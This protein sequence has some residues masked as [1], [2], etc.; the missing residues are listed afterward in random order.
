MAKPPIDSFPY[1][2][3]P[4][5][6]RLQK[7]I[8]SGTYVYARDTDGEIWVLPDG[9]HLHP[10]ILGGGRSAEYAGDLS[11][12]G[13]IILELTNLSGTFQFDDASG[14]LKMATDLERLGFHV[15]SGVVRF[16]PIDGAPPWTLR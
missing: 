10:R 14:L 6:A 5:S 4:R 15:L 13:D 2:R 16:F 8:A 9:P 3:D 12:D 7:G 11:L 1:P